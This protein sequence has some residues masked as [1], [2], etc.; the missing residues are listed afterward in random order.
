MRA[1][2]PLKVFDDT[3]KF[4][5]LRWCVERNYQQKNIAFGQDC[6]VQFPYITMTKVG[7]VLVLWNIIL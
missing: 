1:L 3:Q 4:T 5:S 7:A 2:N 6:S